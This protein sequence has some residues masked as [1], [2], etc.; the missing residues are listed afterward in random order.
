MTVLHS[1]GKFDHKSYKV[2]GGL[3]GVGVSV[4][5]ALSEWLEVDVFRNG[6]TYHQRYIRGVP[7][8]PVAALGK[9]EKRGTKVRFKA[10]AEIFETID[11]EYDV[12]SKRCRELAFLNKGLRISL[13]DERT[14]KSDSFCYEDGIRAFVAHQN[15]NKEVIH[16]DIIYLEGEEPESKVLLEVA[17]QYNKEYSTDNVYSFANNINTIHGG[18]H[19]SGFKSALTR[20]F[21]KYA[22]DHKLL[23]EN[24]EPPEGGDHLEGLVAIVSIKLPDPKFE[25]QTKVKLSNTEV[26]GIVQ[27]IVN[28]KLGSYCE[29]TPQTAKAVIM[30]SIQAKAA[31]EAAR[32]ARE[33]IR[34]K[35]VLSSGNL[36]GKLADCSSRDPDETEIYIVEGESAGGSAKQ[37]R[38]RHFQAILPI[39][40]KIL[41]VEK[42]RLDKIVGSDNIRPLIIALGAGIEGIGDSHNHLLLVLGQRQKAL[43]FGEKIGDDRHLIAHQRECADFLVHGKAELL[44]YRS[45]ISHWF[46]H[47]KEQLEA[48]FEEFSSFLVFGFIDAA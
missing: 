21:N 26:E 12:L 34:R 18:T 37:G 45:F 46:L 43:L 32:K 10:D 35:T 27:Q 9:V 8:G 29:E 19:L 22:R 6:M 47:I 42:A 2:S 3:H 48:L 5:C 15:S 23:K 20:T 36:P 41:N 11:L 16:E 24:D 17:M 39:K 13:H 31:R 30:K 4:V 1:G 40:G 7:T 33:L 25:S 14:G 44:R 38:V 28:D